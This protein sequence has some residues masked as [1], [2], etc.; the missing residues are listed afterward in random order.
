MVVEGHVGMYLVRNDENAA[1]VTEAG[2][3]FQRFAAP[4]D[5]SGIV[6]VRQDEYAAFR[7]GHFGEVVEVHVVG[8]VGHSLERVVHH[9]A[10]VAL[11]REAEGVVDRGLYDN[12]FV[13]LY[14]HVDGHADALHDARNVAEPF[15]LH[16]P[17][18]V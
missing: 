10:S 12:L 2:Q 16:V 1:A 6:W 15:A 9:F 7:V 18:V 8:A 11:W 14:K 5:A 17:V 4:A 3:P 13:G